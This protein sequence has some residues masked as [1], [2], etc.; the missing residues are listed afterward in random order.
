MP[1]N[2][3]KRDKF[4]RVAESRTNKIV[5][6]IALLGNC[7]N[8][9]LY[10][11]TEHDVSEIFGAIE[12]QLRESKNKFSHSMDKKRKSFRLTNK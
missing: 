4:I 12:N 8:R 7:S 5:N 3:S 1:S 10:E 11:Y 9:S 6:M 2:E